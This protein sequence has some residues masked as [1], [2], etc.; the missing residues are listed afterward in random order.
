MVTQG[1]TQCSVTLARPGYKGTCR[2]K[3]THMFPTCDTRGLGT[4][5][6]TARSSRFGGS[7]SEKEGKGGLPWHPTKEEGRCSQGG[8]VNIL[9]LYLK[10][11]KDSVVPALLMA[12]CLERYPE[13]EGL[14]EHMPSDPKATVGGM[15][16]RRAPE[17]PQLSVILTV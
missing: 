15:G 12:L 10:W 9:E 5:T 2:T 17:Y 3:F 7:T 13:N 14:S 16:S 8:R 1:G 11:Q 6:K 4:G